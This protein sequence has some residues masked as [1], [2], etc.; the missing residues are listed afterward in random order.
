MGRQRTPRRRQARPAE[1]TLVALIAALLLGEAQPPPGLTLASAVAGLLALV[2]FAQ[3][4]STE[5]AARLV[6]RDLPAPPRGSGAILAASRGEFGYRAAYGVAAVKR[7]ARGVA[8][9]AS[10]EGALKS[11]MRFYGRHREASARRRA[12]LDATDA[13]VRMHGPV[14]TWSHAHA[15]TPT[16][17]R[18]SHKRADG[19]RV[20]LRVG[21]PAGVLSLPGAEPNCTCAWTN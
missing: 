4:P 14:L 20:D 7:L 9:G 1:E 17:P 19:A 18:V 13:M 16:E 11:E 6:L 21:L 3:A 15:R 5:A 2:P 12:A 8:G 10:L